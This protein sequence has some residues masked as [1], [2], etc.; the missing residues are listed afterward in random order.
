MDSL[1]M[2]RPAQAQAN[3]TDHLDRMARVGFVSH[4]PGNR[5]Q[6]WV[7]LLMTLFIVLEQLWA[8][9]LRVPFGF[10]ETNGKPPW[11]PYSII[12]T[13]RISRNAW[14]PFRYKSSFLPGV[15]PLWGL[16]ARLQPRLNGTKGALESHHFSRL[17]T[18]HCG[19]QARAFSEVLPAPHL[20]VRSSL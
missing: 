1:S 2:N 13:Y 3:G 9:C 14:K 17:N 6:S 20:G 5:V 10:Q 15:T 8:C 4:R 12:H 19:S 7:G 18:P 11:V 16:T